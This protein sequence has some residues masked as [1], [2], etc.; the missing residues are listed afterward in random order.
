[1]DLE[2][3]WKVETN[4]MPPEG[5]KE[6]KLIK[7]KKSERLLCNYDMRELAQHGFNHIED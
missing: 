6:V 2:S 7:L 1:M 4:S 3:K 5:Q